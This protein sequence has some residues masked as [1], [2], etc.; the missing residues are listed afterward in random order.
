MRTPFD[1]QKA[2]QAAHFFVV[3]AG[4]E[5]EI[6]RL[7]KLLYLAD[8]HSLERRRVPI[9]GGTYWSLKHGPVTSEVLDL[10]NDGTRE[11]NSAWERL[12]SDRADHRV[13]AAPWPV[14]YDA[15][16]A[17]E[18]GLLAEVWERFGG[19]GKWD[20]VEWTHR[21]CEEWSDPRG[22]RA[23]ISARRLA[24]SFAWR[25]AEVDAFEAEIAL[26]NRLQEI[27]N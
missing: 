24:E 12:I 11:G 3:R 16:S 7:V 6:L 21:H 5:M 15:L 27:L 2:A 22:G 8:R 17:S 26:R 23:E 19:K 4:G 20:L 14:P 25:P 10:I 13:A 18:L 1:I 9:V